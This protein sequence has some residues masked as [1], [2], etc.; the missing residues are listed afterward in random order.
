MNSNEIFILCLSIAILIMFLAILVFAKGN[1]LFILAISAITVAFVLIGICL[2]LMNNMLN[3]LDDNSKG[4]GNDIGTLKE[5]VKFIAKDNQGAGEYIVE[6][7][8]LLDIKDLP[9]EGIKI[10][11]PEQHIIKDD[12]EENKEEVIQEIKKIVDDIEEEDFRPVPKD[13]LNL[14]QTAVS[15]TVLSNAMQ[16]LVERLRQQN[17]TINQ[18]V[19]QVQTVQ[20]NVTNA[21]T[22]VT[23]QVVN[24]IQND[25]QVQ[26]NIFNSPTVQQTIAQSTTIVN[27]I[28][29]SD[30][31]QHMVNNGGTVDLVPIQDAITNINQTM[32]TTVENIN[33][34][35]DFLAFVDQTIKF[36]DENGN[37]LSVYGGLTN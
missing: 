22:A 35:D 13:T 17:T 29:Q 36:V 33:K 14:D 10:Y 4:V 11:K 25:T 6:F 34:M 2:Y 8:D 7:L 9:T 24:T 18:T 20:T 16:R 1:V 31:I 21:V 27:A 37:S 28:T 23:E 32:N 12:T 19:Q 15:S 30:V 5:A 26:Q 3:R